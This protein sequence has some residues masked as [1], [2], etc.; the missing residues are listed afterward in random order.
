MP[1]PEDQFAAEP[2][3]AKSPAARLPFP[4]LPAVVDL[5]AIEREILGRWRDGRVFDRSLEQTAAGEPWTFYEGPPTA[6]GMPGVHHVEARVFKDL[7]PRFK[8]MQGFH[9]PR[10]GGWDCHGLPVEVAVEQELG[11]SGKKEIEAYGIAEFNARCRESVLRHVDAFEALTERM[12]YWV[13]LQHAY[14]TMDAD[15]VESVWWSL[16][17]VFDKGLLIR[18]YRISPYCPRCETP[19]SDHEMGQPDVYRTVSDPSV[20]VRFPLLTLPEGANE[21]LSGADLLVWTTT[22]WTLVSNTA[23]AVHPDETYAVARKSGDGDRVVVADS[24]FARVL[25]E[26]WHIVA[27]IPGTELAG[28]TYRP[29]FDLVHIPGAHRV[30][31]GTFVTTE[32]GTGL[33]HLAPAFG[34]DDMETG[35]A[36]GLPVINPIRGDGHFEDSVPLVGGMFFKDADP[37]LVSDL[38]DRELLFRSQRHEHSYPHCWRCHTPLIYYALPSWFIRTTAV[39]DEMLA[40]NEKTNWHPETIKH[41]RYGEW[42]RNNVDW[43]LS[44]TRYWG[45]P[46]PLWVC[47]QQHVTCVGSLAELS[48]L[49]GRDL[50][51][52]DPHRPYV[53]EVMI[54]CRQ[55]GSQARRVPEVID[56]W[57]DSGAMPFARHGAPMRN[58]DAFERSFPAQ[59]I[60]EAI[61]QT[62]GWFY[63]LMAVSTLVFGRSSYESVVCLGLVIDEQGRKMSKHL[64]NVLEP[65]PL[66]DAHGADALRWFFA[67]SGSPWATRRV[68]HATLEEIVRKVLLTYWNTVS[69]LVLYANAAAGAGGPA[70][71]AGRLAGAPAAAGRPVL[72]RWLLSEL[73]TLVRDVTIALE[74]FDSALAGRRIAAFIDDLSNWYVRRSRRRFWEGPGTPGGAAAFATLHECLE[75]LTRLMAPVTPFLT[76]YVWGV[77]RAEDSPGSVHLAAWPA[78]DPSLIDERLSGQMALARRLVELGRSARAAAVVRVR[79]PLARALIGASGFGDLPADLRAQV[80]DE[81]NV[82]ELDTL[83]AV[84]EGLVDYTVKPNYR[85]LGGRFGKGTPA[86]ARAIEAADPAA[87]A[88]ELRSGG[89][90]SV[91]AD[92]A[93]VSL[94]PDDV[95]VTQVPRSGWAVA[96][97]GGETVALEIAITPELRREG[98]AREV[99]RLVQDA[100]KGDGLDVSDRIS[101]RWSTADPELAAA[102]TEHGPMISAEVLAV[103]YGAGPGERA[104]PG[105]QEHVD[106]DLGLVF[107]LRRVPVS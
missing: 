33:V 80:A 107:W 32:D 73:H 37:T 15:Y 44:R 9:V 55:C 18:D 49:A 68:G 39:K 84:P 45:T 76:D 103:D 25:G 23:V 101:L 52:L 24:L 27:R 19:L 91:M 88:A 34:A 43:A 28:A 72:D 35:R 86:V 48:E 46:L 54:T 2:S 61:D 60:C 105:A 75:T 97:G 63:S 98:L 92:G 83:A 90:A 71:N 79:Q 3:A 95:I 11:V 59:F 30:V 74:D 93:Q 42:L 65:I 99:V 22:P 40:E 26:G 94:G 57:Y 47:P 13:D 89:K 77:L 50:T 5:P 87:L 104:E 6:N 41:G 66:M 56:A 38:A 8:T 70:W 7:F 16:K 53:D 81:L 29:P 20:T 36:H 64:G 102:L 82:H 62:R 69:F 17:A 10:Q 21:R 100:R 78:A 31:T 67:A 1:R 96:S 12:G 4:E 85:A 58:E 51:G 106:P 14:R